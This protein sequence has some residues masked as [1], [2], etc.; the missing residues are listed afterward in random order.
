MCLFVFFTPTK[1]FLYPGTCQTAR[2]ALRPVFYF[3]LRMGLYNGANMI[4]MQWNLE[5]I[6]RSDNRGLAVWG[7]EPGP[8]LGGQDVGNTAMHF[9]SLALD[10]TLRWGFAVTVRSFHFSP[11]LCL[12]VIKTRRQ[13]L[14]C[15][16]PILIT[17]S[18]CKGMKHV[19]HAWSVCGCFVI[20]WCR[21][22]RIQYSIKFQARI[23]SFLSRRLFVGGLFTTTEL[24][25]PTEWQS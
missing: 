25:Q 8:G 18:S 2:F 13:S 9:R 1:L 10:C 12:P 24:K 21:S 3:V 4:S 11:I 22:I 23:Q 16:C 7:R 5:V 17:I 15:F 6:A 20:F 19:L 14:G